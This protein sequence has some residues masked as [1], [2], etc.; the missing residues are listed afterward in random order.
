MISVVKEIVCNACGMGNG[1]CFCGKDWTV[2]EMTAVPNCDYCSDEQT[3]RTAE[4]DAQ[5][6]GGFWAYMCK[7]HYLLNAKHAELGLG[8][9]QRLV[10][11]K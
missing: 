2:V 4:Y 10:A 6:Y 8:K 9:G 11:V 5:A 3:V 1:D 7:Y